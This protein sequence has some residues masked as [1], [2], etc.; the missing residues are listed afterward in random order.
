MTIKKVKGGYRLVSKK[1]KNLGTYDTE[2][3]AEKRE[4]Q[5]QY[6]KHK[7]GGK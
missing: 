3:G 5:V 1:G 6:F 2:A 4:R 7:K